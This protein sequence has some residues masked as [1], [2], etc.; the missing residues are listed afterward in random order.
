LED[1]GE[2]EAEHREAGDAPCPCLMGH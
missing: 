1:L 2:E